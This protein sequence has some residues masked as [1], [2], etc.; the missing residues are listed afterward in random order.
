[1]AYLFGESFVEGVQWE[2]TRDP[3][4]GMALVAGMHPIHLTAILHAQTVNPKEFE[5]R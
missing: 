4:L 3:R 5:T 2:V 1:M